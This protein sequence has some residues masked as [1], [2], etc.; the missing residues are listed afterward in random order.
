MNGLALSW[1]GLKR[2]AEP[3]AMLRNPGPAIGLICEGYD[4]RLARDRA[5][6][7]MTPTSAAPI[8]AKWREKSV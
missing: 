1:E 4:R 5:E 2:P 7:A 3:V 8:R 6:P